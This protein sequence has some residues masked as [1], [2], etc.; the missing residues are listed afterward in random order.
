MDAHF[1]QPRTQ[2]NTSPRP[3]EVG[4]VLALNFAN[5]HI[6]IFLNTWN[7]RQ[8]GLSFRRQ[9]Y[10]P[11]AGLGVREIEIAAGDEA[12]LQAGCT[13]MLCTSTSPCTVSRGVW[14]A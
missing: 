2:T 9:R 13:D 5:N 8:D 14:S 10:L 12:A 6:R 11:C 1:F 7:G 4:D 3:F